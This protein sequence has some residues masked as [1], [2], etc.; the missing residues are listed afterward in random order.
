MKKIKFSIIALFVA[1]VAF[2][3]CDGEITPDTT[4]D[5]VITF[6]QGDSFSIN[7]GED[8]SVSVSVFAEGELDQVVIK[9]IVDGSTE[10]LETV[11]SFDINTDYDYT[12]DAIDVQETFTITV[13]ATDKQDVAK[14][15]TN[16]ATVTATVPETVVYASLKLFPAPASLFVDS[17]TFTSLTPDFTGYSWETAQGNEATIDLMYYNGRYTKSADNAPHFVSANVSATYTH[18]GDFLS[19]DNTSYFKILDANEILDLGAWSSIDNNDVIKLIDM[20]SSSN[21][22]GELSD[23]TG[24]FGVDSIIAF[25]LSDGKKGVIKVT[26]LVDGNSNGVYYDSTEDYITFDVIVEKDAPV[27]K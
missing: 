10:T 8:V 20:T 5:P 25:M 22:V 6:P 2:T 21:N 11:T 18:G 19:G 16:S 15:T 13:E 12:Y 26:S 24:A 3:A 27:V 7:V 17:L 14:T 1:A 4:A 9:K 23:G